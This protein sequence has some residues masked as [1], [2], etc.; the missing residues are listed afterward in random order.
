MLQIDNVK[1]YHYFIYKEAIIKKFI[2]IFFILSFFIIISS[3]DLF[4]L[5]NQYSNYSN[6]NYSGHYFSNDNFIWPVPGY[7]QITSYFGPRKAPTASASSNHSG[8][9]IAAAEGSSIYS[10]CSGIVTHVG[11]KGAYG[12][13]IIIKNNNMEFLYAHVSPIYIVHIGDYI[14]QNTIIGYVGPKYLSTGN[15]SYMDSSSRYTNGA[16]TGPHLHLGIKKD[17][18]AVNPLLFFE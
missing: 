13:T 8:V 5:S 15:S 2:I 10:V 9:D 3:I 17:G 7:H 12:H 18:I 16:T 4:L 14:T 11:F 6:H 1:N